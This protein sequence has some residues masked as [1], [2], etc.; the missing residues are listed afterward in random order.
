MKK[1]KLNLN[2]LKVESF[3]TNLDKKSSHTVQ[4]GLISNEPLANCG[5][6]VN[7]M[8]GTGIECGGGVSGR[9]DVTGCTTYYTEGYKC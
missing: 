9:T 2:K 4:G 8:Q 7:P 3:V 5:G 1:Q 6:Y